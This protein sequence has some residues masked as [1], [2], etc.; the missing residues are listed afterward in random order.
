VATPQSVLT[1]AALSFRPLTQIKINSR[2]RKLLRECLFYT[3]GNLPM[4]F[5]I[6]GA[7]DSSQKTHTDGG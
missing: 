1:S 4:M 5:N 3:D 7:I 2:R 6:K